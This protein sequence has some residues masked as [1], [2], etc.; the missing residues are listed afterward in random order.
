[1]VSEAVILKTRVGD[2]D[3][4]R[5]CMIMPSSMMLLRKQ[6][7]LHIALPRQLMPR[8]T[9]SGE[10][11]SGASERRLMPDPS[12]DRMSDCSAASSSSD[13]TESLPSEATAEADFP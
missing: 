5:S 2:E 7:S 8:R 1:M 3:L 12:S 10:A 9:L 4:L 11:G 6:I 13:R